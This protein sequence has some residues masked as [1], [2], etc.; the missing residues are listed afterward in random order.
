MSDVRAPCPITHEGQSTIFL[1]LNEL[2]KTTLPHDKKGEHS[3]DLRDSHIAE[4]FADSERIRQLIVGL[5]HQITGSQLSEALGWNFV[6]DSTPFSKYDHIQSDDFTNFS[7]RLH[8]ILSIPDRCIEVV[9]PSDLPDILQHENFFNVC[10]C[11]LWNTYASAQSHQ[12][13]TQALIFC[14]VYVQRGLAGYLAQ[15]LIQNLH[16]NKNTFS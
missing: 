2:L 3:V 16:D 15:G 11:L 7:S 6:K 9:K 5:S 8:G 4:E 14:A 12:L 13:N 10:A 1:Y